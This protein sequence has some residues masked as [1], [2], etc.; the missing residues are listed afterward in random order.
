MR[1]DERG[2]ARPSMDAPGTTAP[3]GGEPQPPVPDTFDAPD[4]PDPAVDTTVRTA[5]LDGLR[6]VAVLLVFGYHIGLKATPLHRYVAPEFFYLQAGVEVFFVLSGFL[7][8]SPFVRAHLAGERAP[9]PL[10]YLRRRVLRIEARASR[11]QRRGYQQRG[12]QSNP[13]GVSSQ[14]AAAFRVRLSYTASTNRATLTSVL[15]GAARAVAAK[16]PW[17]AP[18]QRRFPGSCANRSFT[19]M[20]RDL[21]AFRRK[22][23][24]PLRCAALCHRSPKVTPPP[25]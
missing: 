10:D 5:E 14:R 2:A 9:R 8:Y 23:V 6:A 24:S 7:I 18:P 16:L 13:H 20:S 17:S 12:Q 3:V 1:S 21:H 11:G 22:A 4:Q 19:R 15:H 25:R